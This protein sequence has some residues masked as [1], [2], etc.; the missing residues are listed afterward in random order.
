MQ[1]VPRS[2]P[3]SSRNCTVSSCDRR[4]A[5]TILPLPG[6]SRFVLRVIK[7]VSAGDRRLG[8]TGIS[9]GRQTLML[10]EFLHRVPA[11]R[12]ELL[13]GQ[14]LAVREGAEP[15][16]YILLTGCVILRNR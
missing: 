8:K 14:I 1:T 16:V 4:R 6:Y 12:T 15:L 13:A 9:Q 11:A 2:Y 7:S 3:G 5:R 10:P